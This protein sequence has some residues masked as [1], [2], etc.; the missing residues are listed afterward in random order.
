MAGTCGGYTLRSVVGSGGRAAHGKMEKGSA[1]KDK[2]FP[3]LEPEY[4]A[5]Q[6]PPEG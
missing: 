6:K 3:D 5:K 1:P 2:P 4:S